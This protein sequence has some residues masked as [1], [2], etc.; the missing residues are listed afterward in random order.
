[1]LFTSEKEAALWTA[2]IRII[3]FVVITTSDQQQP[4]TYP[5]R[6]Q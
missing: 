5:P 4:K 1:M 6:Y 2:L 3:W